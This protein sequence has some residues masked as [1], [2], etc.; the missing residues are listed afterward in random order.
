MQLNEQDRLRLAEELAGSVE[1]DAQWWEQW[2]AEAQ[3]RY[4]RLESGEDPGLTVEEFWSD[5]D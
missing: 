3:R 4:A 2:T 5:L 1:P